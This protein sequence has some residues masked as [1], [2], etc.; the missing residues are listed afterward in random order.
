MANMLTNAY[1]SLTGNIAKAKIKIKEMKKWKETDLKLLDGT[2]PGGNAAGGL[3]VGGMGGDALNALEAA[4]E[5]EGLSLVK[6]GLDAAG[7]ASL[8]N[9]MA[10]MMDGYSKE[11]EVQFN[12]GSLQIRA[13]GGGESSQMMQ[14]FAGGDGNQLK[15]MK[16]SMILSV[17]LVFD[18]TDVGAA[19]PA[20]VEG[21]TLTEGLQKAVSAASSAL[22]VGRSMPSVQTVVEGFI[23]ALR[24]PGTR[25]ICFE[26]GDLYYEGLLKGVRGKYTLFDAIGHPVRAEVDLDIYLR[27]PSV[28]NDNGSRKLGYWQSAYEKAFSSSTSYVKGMQGFLNSM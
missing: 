9:E 25:Q 10:H 27:D 26:W 3:G 2:K 5:E 4:A 22:G 16:L 23:G 7:A 17:R 1:A 8:M 28:R 19:F 14:D 21:F 11:F 18:K 15:R 13:S 12:P 6:S 20:S 24:N